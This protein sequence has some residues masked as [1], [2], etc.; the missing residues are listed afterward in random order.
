MNF[1]M[2]IGDNDKNAVIRRV[3][4][5]TNTQVKSGDLIFELESSKTIIEIHSEYE[6]I[7]LHSLEI[8]KEIKNGDTA[9]EIVVKTPMDYL[10]FKNINL[11]NAKKNIISKTK[12]ITARKQSEINNLFSINH[13]ASSS[14][15]S[16][17]VELTGT[18][19]AP[20]PFL[21]KNGISDILVFE[22]AKLLGKYKELNSY[23]KGDGL[24]EEYELVNFGWAFDSGNNLKVLNINNANKISLKELQN[25]VFDLLKIYETDEK[26]PINL[27][28]G[29]TVTFTDLSQIYGVYIIDKN[30]FN[31]I[32]VQSSSLNLM[33]VNAQ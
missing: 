29:S 19:I 6:G 3:F 28:T 16:I 25:L 1:I 10:D 8:G 21:F 33:K 23:F 20:P 17:L 9:F 31:S 13:S 27:V 12:K 5:P 18:R 22:A 2:N 14:V 30:H 26:L 7:L 11:F 32:I 15:I 24:Y 4:I